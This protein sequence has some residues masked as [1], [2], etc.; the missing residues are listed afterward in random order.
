MVEIGR[1]GVKA[2]SAPIEQ[3]ISAYPPQADICAF[4]STSLETKRA[5][6]RPSQGSG[7]PKCKRERV[8]EDRFGSKTVLTPLKQDVC[9]TPRRLLLTSNILATR[10]VRACVALGTWL[11]RAGAKITAVLR[12]GPARQVIRSRA[13]KQVVQNQAVEFCRT[14]IPDEPISVPENSSDSE[15]PFPGPEPRLR[16]RKSR[17]QYGVG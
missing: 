4:A 17:T 14:C 7:L 8:A 3:K 16:R 2:G 15:E 11:F 12:R 5:A 10:Q 13:L 9:I 1:A 6:W